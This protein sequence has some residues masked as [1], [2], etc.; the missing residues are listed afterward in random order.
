MQQNNDYISRINKVMDY[1]EANLEEEMT[2]EKLASVACFSKYHFSRIFHAMTG[3]SLFQ[4]IS[5]VRL[6]KSATLLLGNPNKSITDIA[7]QCGFSDLSVF[8][9]NFK[10]YFNISA[11]DYRKSKFSNNRQMLSN[12]GQRKERV[13]PYYCSET[14]QLKWRSSMKLNESIEVKTLPN[15]TLAYVRYV[16]PYAGD[17]ALFER[18]FGQ[19][20]GWAGPKGLIGGPDMKTL[21][22]YHDSPEITD[23]AKL[24]TSV[25][26][27]VP[28]NTK[29]DGEIGKMKLEGGLYAIG[30][31]KVKTDEFQEAWDMMCGKWLPESGYLPDD[32]PCFEMYPEEMKDGIHTVDICVPVKA[33]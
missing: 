16:G 1:I 5:R 19:L 9:R 15:M 13:I 2:L 32:K 28:E 27:T 7:F 26:I 10:S 11:A 29:V 12:E 33:K 22:I 23:E 14:Q 24:R 18:L 17:G 21:I 20:F 25:C 6:E 8:S 4:F 30:R 31:F 3:E